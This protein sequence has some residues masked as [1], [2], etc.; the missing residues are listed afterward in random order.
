VK[1]T[2]FRSETNG[3]VPHEPKLSEMLSDPVVRAVMETPPQVA[4][5]TGIPNSST[6]MLGP[7]A[8]GSTWI[9]SDQCQSAGFGRTEES[10]FYSKN[11]FGPPTR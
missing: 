2:G 9:P 3:P 6:R 10:S 11:G 1:T 4:T 5:D 8:G 7:K